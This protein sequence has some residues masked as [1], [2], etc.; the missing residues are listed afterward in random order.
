MAQ[1]WAMDVFLVEDSAPV[2]VRLEALLAAIPG[3][4]VVGFA[5]TAE[6]AVRSILEK[7]PHVVVLDMHLKQGTGLDVLRALQGKAGG[8]AVYVLTNY[9]LEAY[10]QAAE[11]LGARG[12]FDKT[13][14]LPKLREALARAAA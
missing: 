5:E 13:S 4:S 7:Q 10:R 3:A 12:F 6:E 2:R 11:R 9:A 1:T 14:D 8:T